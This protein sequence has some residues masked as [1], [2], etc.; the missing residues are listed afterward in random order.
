MN[1]CFQTTDTTAEHGRGG[2]SSSSAD[3]ILALL[4]F[5]EKSTVALLLGAFRYPNRIPSNL[6]QKLQ[7]TFK[8]LLDNVRTQIHP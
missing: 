4:I 1:R 2:C 3:F 5:T 7:H 8:C 6:L